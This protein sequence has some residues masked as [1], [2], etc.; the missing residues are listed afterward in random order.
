MTASVITSLKALAISV[1]SKVISHAI[2]QKVKITVGQ[3]L[4]TFAKSLAIS[5]ETV[6]MEHKEEIRDQIEMIEGD[7]SLISSTQVARMTS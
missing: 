5:Q 2:A 1:V 7:S 3:G 6:Q 4:A